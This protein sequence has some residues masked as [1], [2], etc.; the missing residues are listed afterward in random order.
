HTCIDNIIKALEAKIICVNEPE[1]M[2]DLYVRIGAMDFRSFGR[3]TET[4]HIKPEQSIIV[5]G[6]RYDIQQRSIQSGVRLLVVTGDLEIEEDVIEMAKTKNTC[7]IVSR[8]DSATTSWIIRTATALAP[9]VQEEVMTFNR[10]EKLSSVR[11][12]IAKSNDPLFCVVDDEG[13]LE[14]V[15]TKTDMLKP[16]ETSLVLVDHNELGQA[17]NGAAE[18]NIVEIVD[19]HRLGNP[20][21]SQPILFR[22]EIIGSTC[23]I[24]AELYRARGLDPA[25]EIAGVLMGGIISDTLNLQSPTTTERD[26]NL[27]PWLSGIAGVSVDN[28]AHLIFTA[29]SIVVTQPPDKVVT[30]DCKHYEQGELKYSVSQVE[31]LGFNNFWKKADEIQAALGAYQ[32]QEGLNF[33]TLLVTDINTQNSLLLVAG[34]EETIEQISF[35]PVNGRTDVFDLPGIVSRKKQLIPYFTSLLNYMGVT[36]A[37]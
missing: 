21:T 10:E 13:L 36:A 26:A 32:K 23:S 6:D 30:A 9:L 17:V 29:G 19:H 22:N 7:L 11:R 4:E 33:S 8:F 35:S 18:V 25:P 16:V 12:R 27:L 20:P 1:R 3:F 14:G 15:F 28:L 34:D 37:S 31:E 24:I 2:E 5:V